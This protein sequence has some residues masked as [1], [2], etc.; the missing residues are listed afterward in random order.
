VLNDHFL[1]HFPKHLMITIQQDMLKAKHTG[2]GFVKGLKVGTQTIAAGLAGIV[3]KPLAGFKE[4]DTAGAKVLGGVTGIAQ[5]VA[6]AVFSVPAAA[7]GVIEKTGE[8]I[9]ANTHLYEIQFH[10]GRG[11]EQSHVADQ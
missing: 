9:E 8:G 6:G 7:L 4:G 1:R 10:A 3:T 5:G 11:S 2:D